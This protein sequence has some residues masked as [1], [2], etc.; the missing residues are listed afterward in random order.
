VLSL[1][2]FFFP[3]HRI[4]LVDAQTQLCPGPERGERCVT[5]LEGFAPPEEIRH[6]FAYMERALE[7][8]D[9]VIA[10]SSFLAEKM[11]GYFPRLQ[12]RLR[13]VPLGVKPVPAK[14]KERQPGTPLRI[15]Y[16]GL[17][18]P[19]KGAHVL[20]EA[21]KGLPQDALE[22]SLYGASLPFWQ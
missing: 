13:V 17:L 15:L 8:P 19:P 7:A 6:R 16:V 11:L 9:L 12:E 20:L 10:P 18:F 3:C 14:A 4:H 5:C 22:V 2:D 21:L 1:H